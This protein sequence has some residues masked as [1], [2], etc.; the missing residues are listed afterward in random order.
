LEE[1]ISA[2]QA[3]AAVPLAFQLG[4]QK[5]GFG[6]KL[7]AGAPASLRARVLLGMGPFGAGAGG[8][9]DDHGQSAIV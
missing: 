5:G 3:P 8:G 2:P 9:S 6:A 7:G 1:H 4:G